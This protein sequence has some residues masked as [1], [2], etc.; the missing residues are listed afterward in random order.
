MGMFNVHVLT[1]LTHVP[2]HEAMYTHPMWIL[3]TSLGVLAAP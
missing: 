1:L 2:P 3:W